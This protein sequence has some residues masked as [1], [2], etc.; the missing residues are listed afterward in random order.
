MWGA[1]SP[2]YLWILQ[3]ITPI[4]SSPPP[5]R[6]YKTYHSGMYTPR[7]ME[8]NITSS[9]PG[10]YEPYYKRV[11]TPRDA[12]TTITLCLRGYYNHIT[13]SPLEIRNH[14]TEG[15]MPPAIWGAILPSHSWILW[16]ILKGGGVHLSLYGEQYHPLSPWISQSISQGVYTSRGMGSNI[17]LFP[18]GYYK[19]YHRR[20]HTA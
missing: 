2:S 13:V 11:Y 19:P 17:T 18:P 4:S 16:N 10:Y 9:F 6:Y 12:R 1:I 15:C 7:D 14:I 8:S 5:P 3:T 20:V